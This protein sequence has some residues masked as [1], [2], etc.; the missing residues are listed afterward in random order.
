MLLND[1]KLPGALRLI[2]P[3]NSVMMGFAVLIGAV[4]ASRKAIEGESWLKLSLGFAT[5]FALTA[6][7][8]V[9]NDYFDR[10]VDAVN[11]PGRPI[12][13]GLVTPREA[14]L[15]GVLWTILGFATACATGPATLVT[16]AA[17]WLMFTSYAVGGKRTGLPGNLLVSGCVVT[18]FFYGA[19]LLNSTVGVNTWLFAAM[20]FLSNTGREVTKGIPDAVGD[21]AGGVKTIAVRYGAKVAAAGSSGLYT[22]AVLLSPIPWVLGTVSALYLP[23]VA[24]ADAGFISSSVSLLRDPSP[25]N[26]HRVKSRVLIWMLLGLVAFLLGGVN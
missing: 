23:L 17:A 25:S 16:A 18:P 14:A 26:S 10:E 12:P 1:A 5:G 11:Q 3:A 8:M 22:A 19:L 24:A 21:R 4:L 2:R 7:S 13:S 20:A 9:F 15:W 6:A